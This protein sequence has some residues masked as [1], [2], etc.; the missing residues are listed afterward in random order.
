MS[1]E[2]KADSANRKVRE[3]LDMLAQKRLS[4]E[5]TE[6]NI[7]TNRIVTLLAEKKFA[8]ATEDFNET[9]KSSLPVEKLEEAWNSTVELL[10]PFK[11]QIGLRMEKQ[12]GVNAADANAVLVTCE[13]ENGGVDVKIV[14]DSNDRVA[15]LS[16][17]PTPPAV[18]D[19]YRQA[20]A[21]E[22][23][24]QKR[25]YI[26]IDDP[27]TIGL[28][29]VI[30]K[31]KTKLDN[32]TDTDI[33]QQ[34]ELRRLKNR[35]DDAMAASFEKEQVLL[36]EKEKYQQ[37]VD[38]IKKDYNDL[39]VTLQQTSEQQ[40]QTLMT[41]LEEEKDN[42]K[43]LNQQLLKTEAELAIAQGRMKRAQEKLDTLVPPPDVEVAAYKPDG[44]IILI[45]E[46]TKVVHLNIGSDDHVYRGL[47]F[48]VYEK[49]TPIPR[50]GKGKAEIE[51]FNVGKN[52]STA[53][54]VSSNLR[55]PVIAGDIIANLIWDS[56]KANVFAVA[57]EF[58]LNGDGEADYEGVDKI[59]ALIRKW[60]GKVTDDISVDTDFLVLGATPTVQRKP[61]FEQTEADPMAMERYEASLKALASYKEMQARAEALSIPKFNL[62]RFL[63]FIGYK[64]LSTG[65]GAFD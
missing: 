35:F 25:P 18:L 40:V 22:V 51:V 42:R 4:I 65:P 5:S 3:L 47:T 50:D 27:N 2:V 63:Y 6:P 29:R 13:F 11:R 61:T 53:R 55:N 62:E 54:I 33:A 57:G 45:D 59:K 28:V 43:K 26:E 7:P 10:G 36:A 1:A 21:P 20:L 37:Q 39:K 30:E 19:S 60:G 58:D 17:I 24:I 44:K 32:T 14:Y 16:L 23:K 64:T 41:Q 38:D 46:A 15:G 49:N 31:L 52:T 48:Q 34:E 12:A 56:N 8:T 9:L